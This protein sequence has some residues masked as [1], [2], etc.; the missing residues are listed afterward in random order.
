VA[1]A[2]CRS[3]RLTATP[4]I[5]DLAL[6]GTT[7][8]LVGTTATLAVTAY[9]K[10]NAVVPTPPLTWTSSNAGV[11]SV[12]AIGLMRAV[13][14]GTTTIS[15]S[16]GTVTGMLSVTVN[17]AP[18]RITIVAP[19]QL[20][21]GNS[22]PLSLYAVDSSGHPTAAPAALWGSSNSLFAYISYVGASATL[23]AAWPGSVTIRASAGDLTATAVVTIVGTVPDVRMAITPIGEFGDSLQIAP[24]QS[25]RLES[26]VYS[27]PS[28]RIVDAGTAVWSSDHPD[29]ASVGSDGVVTAH[30]SGSA[31]ILASIGSVNAERAIKVAVTPGSVSLRLVN[32]ADLFGPLL[33]NVNTGKPVTLMLGDQNEQ[34]VP[35]GTVQVTAPNVAIN[36]SRF[37]LDYQA[38]QQFIGFIAAGTHLTLLAT[39]NDAN[40][41]QLFGPLNFIPIWDYPRAVP[42]DSVQVQVVLA[43]SGGGYNVY[44]TPVGGG[45][46]T[47]FLR[48]CYLD[49]PYG[50]TEYTSRPLGSFDIAL[51]P[52]KTLTEPVFARLSV[53]PQPGHATT[54]VITGQKESLHVTPVITR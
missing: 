15:A 1:L 24:G 6:S 33:L 40:N 34:Q 49:W 52:G 25:M 26:H 47:V 18:A 4:E 54:Y 17:T 22:A 42:A 10:S 44:F 35:A 39:N 48:G 11:A 2:E 43:T 36:L 28:G 8:M 46:S 50:V 7:T 27:A 29:V 51:Q 13:G 31:T 45:I 9:S 14:P 30:A 23:V 20:S 37:F 38:T 41:A 19:T 32:L 5:V 53:T 16:A 3:D 12:D 21:I